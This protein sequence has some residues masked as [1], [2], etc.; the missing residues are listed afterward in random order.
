MGRVNI[1]GLTPPT[2]ASA[3]PT[4]HTQIFGKYPPTPQPAHISP[5]ADCKTFP[6]LSI[7]AGVQAN[8]SVLPYKQKD[9]SPCPT[10]DN[11]QDQS[12]SSFVTSFAVCTGISPPFTAETLFLGRNLKLTVGGKGKIR[13]RNSLAVQ[14]LG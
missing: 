4:P 8:F 12:P 10:Y 5:A 14:W 11:G 3:H 1:L 13:S 7:F 2:A 9:Q 6:P